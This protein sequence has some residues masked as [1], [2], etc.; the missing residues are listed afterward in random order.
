MLS[1]AL[2]HKEAD[3]HKY[4]YRYIHIYSMHTDTRNISINEDPLHIPICFCKKKRTY[5]QHTYQHSLNASKQYPH[6]FQYTSEWGSQYTQ[7]SKVGFV[8]TA[9]VTWSCTSNA[10]F[11]LLSYNNIN[12]S[13]CLF[14]FS[15]AAFC[16]LSL[17][18]S[19]TL[20][21]ST[22]HILL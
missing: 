2:L 18:G 19:Q 17:P 12:Q 15:S 7:R 20:F 6:T 4:K 10:S 16:C 5:I 3:R 14:G 8:F 9:A 21:T 13:E 11:M 22:I 1:D